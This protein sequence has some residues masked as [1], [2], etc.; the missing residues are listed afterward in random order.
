MKNYRVTWE[1][2]V[3]AENPREAAETALL[4]MQD[5]GSQATCFDVVEDKT[6][7]G[8]FIDLMEEP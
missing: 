1:I 5:Q 2:E 3:D 8:F 6:A 7:K 4:I